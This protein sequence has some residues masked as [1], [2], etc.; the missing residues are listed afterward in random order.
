[1]IILKII[2]LWLL[3]GFA[4]GFG[5]LFI[6]KSQNYL[7]KPEVLEKAKIE[8]TAKQYEVHVKLLNNPSI[9]L[10]IITLMGPIFPFMIAF[11]TLVGIV[12]ILSGGKFGKH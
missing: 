8:K 1:M 4:S 12:K 11:Y 10:A 3:T 9:L 7:L 6:A 5:V 2:I